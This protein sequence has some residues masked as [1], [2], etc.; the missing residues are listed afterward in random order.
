MN[1]QNVLIVNWG[2]PSAIYPLKAATSLPGFNI[3][4]AATSNL[5]NN[6]KAIFPST[7]HIVTNP[8]K[9][10][11]L[12]NDVKIFRKKHHLDFD[13]VTTFFEM[14]VYQTSQLAQAL[15]TKY[16]LPPAIADSTSANKYHMREQLRKVKTIQPRYF[17]FK[18][19]NIQAG[20][21]YL[22][23][24]KKPAII[25]PNHSG[26]SYG[27]RL[28]TDSS[29][30]LKK[31]RQLINEIQHE[32]TLNYDEWMQYEKTENPL[33]LI[34]EYI[35]GPMIGI[36]GIVGKLG[37][38]KLIPNCEFLLTPPPL[39][40]QIGHAVPIP[41]LSTTQIK[42]CEEYVITIINQ[43]KLQYCGFHCEIKYH[44]HQPYLI[45]ISGRLPGGVL[46]ESLQHCSPTNIVADFLATFNNKISH[47]SPIKQKISRSEIFIN[48]F[49]HHSSI[50]LYHTP[51]PTIK[52][53]VM[54]K[55]NKGLHV[56]L[57]DKMGVWLYQLIIR[58]N[59]DSSKTLMKKVDEIRNKIIYQYLPIPP[60]FVRIWSTIKIILK[61]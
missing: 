31:F 16:Y 15:K 51:S 38:I 59:R 17:L 33:L 19:D 32:L 5:P 39:L 46:L 55:T 1:K 49:C 37:D 23:Q 34:E 45:E 9:T 53:G 47:P 44:N 18:A 24:L 4:I 60:L 58:S 41:S 6:I 7:H 50:L 30:S 3:Y 29:I 13:I 22:K 48:H 11:Q 12:I 35:P 20:Y 57:K 43:L 26:H 56:N 21:L 42:Q 25:K 61:I 14:S 54:Y 2:T 52:N 8:Y 28:I 40:Q 36:N 27:A 10:P